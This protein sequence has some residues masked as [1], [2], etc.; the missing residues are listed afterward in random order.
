[1]RII[2]VL[3]CLIMLF[4]MSGCKYSAKLEEL[5][6]DRN[7]SRLQTQSAKEYENNEENNEEVDDMTQQRQ[8]EDSQR[9]QQ[10]EQQTPVYG[11][12]STTEG[13]ASPNVSGGSTS[14]SN[15]SQSSDSTAAGGSSSGSSGGSAGTS[16]DGT[17]GTGTG[18]DGDAGYNVVPGNGDLRTIVDANG[19]EVEI[20]ED[21]TSVAA[22]GSIATLF[23]ITGSESLIKASSEDFTSSDLVSSD[24]RSEI[25]TVWGGDGG[26]AMSDASFQTLLELKPEVCIEESGISAFSDSQLEQ[27]KTAGIAY[28]VLPALTSVDNL[29][30]AV[31]LVAEMAGGD[32]SS[33]ASKYSG[34]VDDLVSEVSSRVKS[35]GSSSGLPDISRGSDGYY[36]GMYSLY[37]AGWDDTAY[38]SI[39][40]DKT[41]SISGRGSAWTGTSSSRNGML[42]RSLMAVAGVEDTMSVVGG[43]VARN[44][45]VT[46]LRP[47]T[48]KL[49]ITGSAASRNTTAR[50][51]Q[52]GNV[53][54]GDETFPAVIVN[55][56]AAKSALQQSP[57]WTAY[58][59]V[60]SADGRFEANGFLAPDD[61]IVGTSIAGNYDVLV[62]PEGIGS[63]DR[64]SGESILEAVW[65]ASQFYGAYSESEVKEK[66][67]EFYS[68]FYRISL[69]DSQVSS[70]LNGD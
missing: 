7:S 28:V 9:Q 21:I 49:T 19:N 2:A 46:P 16:G 18:G 4:S 11:S 51:L 34:Y 14:S 43:T 15:S 1:M 63:W 17:S 25:Q 33:A 6:Q 56:N 48:M 29:K 22:V 60:Q 58:G 61:S 3:L 35:K 39:A 13:T 62:N 36:K 31:S 20:P 53:G 26:Q 45:Y 57:L 67:K 27:L 8:S 23:Y 47:V 24:L 70:I 10:E 66:V 69:S 38:Y 40:S 55:S 52:V 64:G 50:L 44:E 37:L 42:V 65:I 5:I 32:S 41:Q 59:H 68:T 30:S 12:T 54:L